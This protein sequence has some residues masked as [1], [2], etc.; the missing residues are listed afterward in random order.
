MGT[1]PCM[2]KDIV[3]VIDTVET[4]TNNYIITK[5]KVNTVIVKENEILFK[6]RQNHRF[7]IRSIV[8]MANKMRSPV[9]LVD[10]GECSDLS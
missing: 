1:I 9:S 2:P 6:F 10:V 8:N 7:P 4:E 5:A 3:Y